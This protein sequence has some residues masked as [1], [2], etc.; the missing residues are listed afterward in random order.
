[1]ARLGRLLGSSANFGTLG[2]FTA[3]QVATVPGPIAGAG[4]PGLMM[5]FGGL[6]IWWRR[7]KVL[8]A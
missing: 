8:A 5:A 1:M 2:T 6:G 4:L 3:T 7:R